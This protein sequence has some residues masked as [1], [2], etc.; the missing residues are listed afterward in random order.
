MA[1]KSKLYCLFIHVSLLHALDTRKEK[2]R[3]TRMR[4]SV[5]RIK[6]FERRNSHAVFNRRGKD[7]KVQTLECY[8]TLFLFLSHSRSIFLVT[9]RIVVFFVALV[10]LGFYEKRRNVCN[11]S[12][13]LR[14]SFPL[15]NALKS[16]R[17]VSSGLLRFACGVTASR[18][19]RFYSCS[20]KRARP[21]GV[22]ASS[23]AA[24]VAVPASLHRAFL[25][26]LPLPASL[27]ATHN[28]PPPPASPLFAIC[29]P[30]NALALLLSTLCCCHFC[31]AA[32]QPLPA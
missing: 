10:R 2:T 4:D 21:R 26:P 8:S 19:S 5:G 27:A 20:L 32:P 11:P 17:A 1:R 3:E 31:F 7:D 9:R 24:V 25:P 6:G 13:P 18:R 28:L 12:P 16:Y 15:S 29:A 23:I 14:L 30:R 22:R